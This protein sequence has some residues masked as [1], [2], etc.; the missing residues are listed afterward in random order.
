[1]ISVIILT[2][3]EQERIEVCLQSV[4]WA[5]EI[6]IVD[7]NS[8]DDTLEIAKK[9]TNKIFKFENL[10]Y[11]SFRNFAFDKS[12]G[13]WVL[14]IDPDERVLDNLREEIQLLTNDS[15]H[16]AYAISRKNIIFGKEVKYG[17]FSPDWVIRLIK[18]SEFETWVGKIHEYVKFNG[19][20]GYAK[21]SLLH[22]THRDIDQIILKSLEWSKIDAKLRL[23]HH[24]PKMNS[25]RFIRILMSELFNQGIVRGGFFNGSV[26]TMDSILQS[27][28]MFITYVRLWQFQQPKLLK[29]IY[30]NL[31]RKL[32]KDNFK[33]P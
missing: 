9:Y 11:A 33:Y 22:L 15:K 21:N 25:W 23:D 14:Y 12:K 10:D 26:G 28:S 3:N 31:D 8:S 32:I 4:K 7:N 6:I 13:D 24:H 19:S 17:S 1:M 5:D 20:L 29:E 16:A 27:F 30:D 18:R 2:K